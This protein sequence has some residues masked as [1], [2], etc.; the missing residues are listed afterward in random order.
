MEQEYFYIQK[1]KLNQSSSQ[2]IRFPHFALTQSNFTF[3][4]E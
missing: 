3:F 4:E 1:H 2:V